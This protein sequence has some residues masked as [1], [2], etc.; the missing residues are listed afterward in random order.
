MDW[1]VSDHSKPPRPLRMKSTAPEP[2]PMSFAPG[3][4]P[5]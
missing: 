5:A 2:V 1:F 3:A 4:T